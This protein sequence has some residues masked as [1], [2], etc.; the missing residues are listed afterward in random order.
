MHLSGIFGP[1]MSSNP[2]MFISIK[3]G[4]WNR[5]IIETVSSSSNVFGL[6]IHTDYGQ[7]QNYCYN[8]FN[9]L[10]ANDFLVKF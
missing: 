7:T 10:G 1:H 2:V 3:N 8:H 9:P 5:K 4:R 6:S